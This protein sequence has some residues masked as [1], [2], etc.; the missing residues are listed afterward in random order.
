M[1]VCLTSILNGE[2]LNRDDDR[3]STRMLELLQLSMCGVALRVPPDQSESDRFLLS[4]P[5]FRTN[6]TTSN[7][8]CYITT[9]I[10]CLGPFCLIAFLPFGSVQ[11]HS[12][13]ASRN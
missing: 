2:P 3:R 13:P 12:G 7:K 11:L 1:S 9:L 4:D 8:I 6:T 5:K 10:V